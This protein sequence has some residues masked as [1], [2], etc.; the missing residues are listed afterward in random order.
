M[1]KVVWWGAEKS[2]KT[3]AALRSPMPLFHMELD[4]GG[5]ERAI[6]L[7]RQDNPK[8]R[9]KVCS[10]DE[11]VKKIDWSKYDIISKPYPVST[12]IN[13]LIEKLAPR[14]VKGQKED[15]K[16]SVKLSPRVQ[17]YRELWQM[18][19]YDY[20]TVCQSPVVSIVADSATQLWVVCHTAELQMKQELQV[21][22]FPRLSESDLREKLQPVEY[23]KDR[24]RQ[25]IYTAVRFKKNLILT[26]YPKDVYAGRATAT[27]IEQYKTGDVVIDGFSDT[28]RLIDVAIK[29]ETKRAPVKDA[30]GKTTMQNTITATITKCAV[31][32]MGTSAVGLQLPEVSFDGLLELQRSMKGE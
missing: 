16:I 25:L 15:G 6:W 26:H 1:V 3:T 13:N 8:V 30:K 20:V 5:F 11:D 7:I 4:L 27:G 23:P 31:E 2:W 29:L 17:G 12:P 22:K 14:F 9:V 19:V 10:E 28:E 21:E 18:L 24:M 32:G